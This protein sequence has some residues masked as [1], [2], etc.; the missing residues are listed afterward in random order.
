MRRFR[1]RQNVDAGDSFAAAP[2]LP[3]VDEGYILSQDGRQATKVAIT[4]LGVVQGKAS[5][6]EDDVQDEEREEWLDGNFSAA[7]EGVGEVNDGLFKDSGDSLIHDWGDNVSHVQVTEGDVKRKRYESSTG[8][9]D[10]AAAPTDSREKAFRCSVCG[11]GLL[12]KACCLAD[13]ARLPLHRIQFWT[14]SFWRKTSLY[15]QGFCYQLGH[16]GAKCRFPGKEQTMTVMGTC[17]IQTVLVARCG[18][19]RSDRLSPVQEL[20]RNGWYPA[21]VTMPQT[22]ATFECLDQFRTLNVTATVNIRDYDRYKSLG[23]MLRQ[24]SF[25]LRMKRAGRGHEKGGITGTKPG[26]SAVWCW[27]CPQVGINLLNDW[28]EAAPADRFLYML[29]IAMDVNFQLKNRLWANARSD[30]PL[31]G[32]MA[33]QVEEKAYRQHLENYISTCIAFAALVQKKNTR[34]S[35]GLRS[36]G[37]SGC[38]CS[39]HELVRPLGIGDLQKGERYANMD[40]IFFSA[41]AM[42]G[43][44]LIFLTYDI[45][46]QYRVNLELRSESMPKQLRHDFAATE[47]KGGLPIW[48]GDVHVLECRTEH[49]IQYQEGTTKLDSEAPERCWAVLNPISY[50]TKEMGLGTWADAIDDCIDHHNH[51]KNVRL[52]S[53]LQNKLQ[54]AIVECANQVAEFQEMSQ[55]VDSEIKAKWEKQY[56]AWVKDCANNATPFAPAVSETVS[57]AQVRLD[58]KKE[59]AAAA[60]EGRAPV[61]IT[62]ASLFMTL[63]L[64]LEDSQRRIKAD[65]AAKSHLATSE[66][67]KLETRRYQFYAKLK[68]F[69]QQQEHYMPEAVRAIAKEEDQRDVNA[70]PPQAEDIKLWLP[71]EMPSTTRSRGCVKGLVEMEL[72]LRVAQCSDCL[73]SIR[74]RLH[75]KRHFINYRN[76]HIVGQHDGMRARGMIDSVG[77][78][79]T[80]YATKYHAVRAALMCLASQEEYPRF[81]P[82]A[83][84]DIKLDIEIMSDAEATKKLTL[85]GSSRVRIHDELRKEGAADRRPRH[86]SWIW[87]TIPGDGSE[88]VHDSVRVEWSKARARS[89]R[90]REEVKLLKEE[91]RRVRESLLFLVNLWRERATRIRLEEDAAMRSGLAAYTFLQEDHSLRTQRRFQLLWENHDTVIALAVATEL[92]TALGDVSGPNGYSHAV[93]N[94]LQPRVS[95]S[96]AGSGCSSV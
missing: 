53:T 42:C 57:E 75:A 92:A 14:G 13:H 95:S 87:L 71:S 59:D 82:L 21:T 68:R 78:H 10:E 18:C 50:A 72:K 63:G 52:S 65:A 91:M 23:R 61:Q 35:T 79:V 30:P 66:E 12:C 20:L 73:E 39:R 45:Y 48:H 94:I 60:A 6:A 40:F 67:S 32:G 47:I 28:K 17:S 38:V 43:L 7:D 83:D 49:Q 86:M 88:M 81:R 31:G 46:C 93:G 3:V 76:T 9:S 11:P 25:L 33:Y 2:T 55:T 69:H 34:L 37:V 51:T 70:V 22:C 44:A 16:G 4:G 27:A 5:E 74:N 54:V 19:D 84:A 8:I 90:W 89:R 58:L 77:D 41:I 56:D 85:Q 24:Y 15:E 64:E 1:G 26:G 29:F 36:S 96:N 80:F 62:S